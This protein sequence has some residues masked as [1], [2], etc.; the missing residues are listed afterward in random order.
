MAI[1]KVAAFIQGPPEATRNGFSSTDEADLVS[2]LMYFRNQVKGGP[3]SLVYFSRVH[4]PFFLVHALPGRSLIISGVGEP[5]IS[6]R[7]ST[8]PSLTNLREQLR[9]IEQ[10][11]Q[12]PRLLGVVIQTF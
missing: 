3:I 6:V 12:V 4:I 2:A 7:H 8:M 1:T 10:P 9:E 11:E 5:K